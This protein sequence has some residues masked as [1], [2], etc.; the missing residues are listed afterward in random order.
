ML[1]ATKIVKRFG[2]K[3]IL[4]SIDLTVEKG[5]IF[6]F[7]GRNGAGKSTFINILTGI[8]QPSSGQVRYFNEGSLTT[9]LKKRIGVLPDYT[10]FYDHLTA[11]KHLQ[12]FA[13]ISGLK[14]SKANCIA[15]L[16]KV[17]L[18]GAVHEKVGKFSFGMKKKLGIAQAV[19][20]NPEFIFLDEPTSG[21]DAESA[22]HLQSFIKE[23]KASGKTIFLTSHNLYE[24][25]KLCD[26][27][28]ILKD[29]HIVKCGTMEELRARYAAENSVSIKYKARSQ[30][31]REKILAGCTQFGELVGE[32]E[33][34]LS[35]RVQ[36]EQH[37]AHLLRVFHELK[38]DVYRVEVNETSLEDIFIG[39]E[40]HAE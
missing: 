4:H 22:I 32:K 14:V 26:R 30:G 34:W 36:Q 11:L 24:V 25:E 8:L 39:D 5:E 27:I 29:G 9:D 38:T 28:A 3:Q 37:I 2:N 6:G 33:G 7:L 35:F 12:Y 31:I 1:Q 15:L 20:H 40:R 23:L 17:G 19:I 16:A 13:E 18:Q 21:I 10:A